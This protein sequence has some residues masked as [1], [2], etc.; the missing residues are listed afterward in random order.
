MD[1]CFGLLTFLTQFGDAILQFINRFATS[2]GLFA[3]SSQQIGYST[4]LKPYSMD[5]AV[6][7]L[8]TVVAI[9]TKAL[10]QRDQERENC[11]GSNWPEP[12]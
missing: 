12:N 1:A 6:A 11:Q 5:A 2:V 8:V 4:E 7:L 10:K 3:L 9:Q